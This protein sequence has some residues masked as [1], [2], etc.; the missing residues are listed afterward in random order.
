MPTL[1]TYFVLTLIVIIVS[2]SYSKKATTKYPDCSSNDISK[3]DTCL[4]GMTLRQAISKLNIDTSQFYV[5]EEPIFS[6]RGISVK[7][8][9]SSD[10]K[11]YVQKTLIK[12][13]KDSLEFSRRYLFI[14]DK[15]IK[16]VSWTKDAGAT[17]KTVY[18][19]VKE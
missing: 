19:P 11:L 15:Q 2:C 8:N 13:R 7:I 4:L 6:L 14:I 16:M 17:Y 3:M 12:E 9:D 18:V 5:I 1:F 10:I